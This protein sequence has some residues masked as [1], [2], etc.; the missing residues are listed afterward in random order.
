MMNILPKSIQNQLDAAA[1]T[2][3]GFLGGNFSLDGRVRATYLGGGVKFLLPIGTHIRPYALGGI[4]MAHI[5]S[6]VIEPTLGDVLDQLIANGLVRRRE[7]TGTKISG[8]VGGGIAIPVGRLVLDGGYRFMKVKAASVSRITG[9][10][11]V[12]F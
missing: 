7:V 10:V 8:E 12:R 6:S 1:E 5:Q 11:G 4:G 2:V 3:R 9:A